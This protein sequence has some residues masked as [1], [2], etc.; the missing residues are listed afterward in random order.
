[1]WVVKPSTWLDANVQGDS[2]L[3]SKNNILLKKY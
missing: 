3:A 1:M 2:I